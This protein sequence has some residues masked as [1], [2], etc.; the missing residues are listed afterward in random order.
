MAIGN[1]GKIDIGIFLLEYFKQEG[2]EN[3]QEKHKKALEKLA[4]YSAGFLSNLAVVGVGLA[5]FQK[6]DLTASLS[7]A[8]CAFV[9]GAIASLFTRGE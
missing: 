4:N 8:V 6:E 2:K 5:I 9:L 1:T 3:M 7:A